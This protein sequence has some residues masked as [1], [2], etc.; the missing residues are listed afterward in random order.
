MAV[1]STPSPLAS[2][3]T[4]RWKFFGRRGDIDLVVKCAVG[5]HL[6]GERGVL[7]TH[8]ALVSDGGRNR[9]PLALASG[10]DQLIGDLIVVFGD[11]AQ[12]GQ[13]AG[14]T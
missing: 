5:A 11:D 1:H 8:V 12:I 9:D 13:P 3:V 14:S 6:G 4:A 10:H 7:S 2:T